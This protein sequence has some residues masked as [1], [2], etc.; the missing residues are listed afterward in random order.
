MKMLPLALL[1]AAAL[2]GGCAGTR[3]TAESP[4]AP[5]AVHHSDGGATAIRHRGRCKIC[6]CR[7][8][9]RTPVGRCRRKNCQ[10]IEKQH[11]VR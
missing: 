1:L 2:L 7:G 11:H 6:N 5:T 8:Y 4:S 9:K 10:H 3:P